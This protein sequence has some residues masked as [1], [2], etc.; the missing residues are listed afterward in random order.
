M[1][2]NTQH[3]SALK[4]SVQVRGNPSADIFQTC[5]DW[6]WASRRTHDMKFEGNEGRNFL[7]NPGSVSGHRMDQRG[8]TI[9]KYHKSKTNNKCSNAGFFGP[10]ILSML[11]SFIAA[12]KND[13]TCCCSKEELRIMLLLYIDHQRLL[14]IHKT[15][16]NELD[17]WQVGSYIYTNINM[18]L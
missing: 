13:S 11:T 1:V 15:T 3:M 18:V 16:T 14:L 5:I 12:A 10:E 2:Y 17:T 6:F 7:N 4:K 9:G 8:P